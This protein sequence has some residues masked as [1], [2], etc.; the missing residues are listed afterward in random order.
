MTYTEA[1]EASLK[2]RWKISTCV[3][4]EACWCRTILPEEEIIDDDGNEIYIVGDGSISKEHAEHIV[5]LHNESF[6]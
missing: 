1:K 5:K 3:S 2:V 6:I 4:G